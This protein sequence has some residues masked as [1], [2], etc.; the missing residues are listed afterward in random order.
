VTFEFFAKIAKGSRVVDIEKLRSDEVDRLVVKPKLLGI[1]IIRLLL[2]FILLLLSITNSF[3]LLLQVSWPDCTESGVR[4][5]WYV[6]S[7]TFGPDIERKPQYCNVL[8]LSL[9]N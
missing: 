5:T 7:Y 1:A 4:W 2:M 6:C 8:S 3:N 9:N